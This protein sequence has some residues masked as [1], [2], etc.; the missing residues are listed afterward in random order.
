ME[1]GASASEVV[2]AARRG[3]ALAEEAAVDTVNVGW[4][5]YS[6]GTALARSGD[7]SRAAELIDPLTE[8]EARVRTPSGAS[9]C[10]PIS[11]S[12]GGGSPTPG[13]GPSEPW[14]ATRPRS[15]CAAV[16]ARSRPRSSCG[17]AARPRPSS[18]IGDPAPRARRPGGSGVRRAVLH[19]RRPCGRRSRR[20]RGPRPDACARIRHSSCIGLRSHSVHDP[21]A[22]DPAHRATW[23]AELARLGGTA[24]VD[25]WVQAGAAWDRLG[26][27]HDAAY[28]RWRARA[29]RAGDRAR[30]RSRPAAE[31]RGPGRP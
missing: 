10:G 4:L 12:A 1:A 3:L 26:R 29:G 17:R 9:W 28:C 16:G 22:H 15:T 21:L 18:R 13:R 14:S 11:T 19:P 25:H 24:T 5:R 31:A 8:D 30:A 27:P 20:G 7:V 23:D 6:L 2:A